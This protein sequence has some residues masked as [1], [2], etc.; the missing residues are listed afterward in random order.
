MGSENPC[1]ESGCVGACCRDMAYV[2]LLE[3][4]LYNFPKAK[5][6]PDWSDISD[7][8]ERGMHFQVKPGGRIIARINGPCEN[9]VNGICSI[10]NQR[11]QVCRN[12]EFGSD[13]CQ[14]ARRASGVKP[15]VL[16]EDGG[17]SSRGN[18]GIWRRW[19]GMD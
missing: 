8:G 13:A 19:L 1:V 4:E 18:R 7:V 15:I 6:V 11:P 16:E 10:Y 17:T 14:D 9:L 12:F 3:K 2:P 5:K